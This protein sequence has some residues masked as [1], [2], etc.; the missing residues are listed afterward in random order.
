MVLKQTGIGPVGGHSAVA[1]KRSS[2]HPTISIRERFATF[3]VDP[4]QHPITHKPVIRAT[5]AR[6]GP[7]PKKVTIQLRG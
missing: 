4:M 7:I 6:V 2:L 1:L 5:I 3:K